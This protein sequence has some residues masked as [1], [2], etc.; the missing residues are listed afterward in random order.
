MA[1]DIWL[2][3]YTKKIRLNIREDADWEFI[4]ILV[5]WICNKLILSSDSFYDIID[6]EPYLK[7]KYTYNSWIK[8]EEILLEAMNYKFPYEIFADCSTDF[9]STIFDIDEWV[10]E[11]HVKTFYDYTS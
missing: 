10:H 2:R 11:L 5:L 9:T 8:S 4:F 7:N 3:I 6:F 1:N